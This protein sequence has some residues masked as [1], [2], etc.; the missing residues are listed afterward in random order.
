MAAVWLARPTDGLWRR[1]SDAVNRAL[2]ERWL[3]G[4]LERVLKTDLFD[5]AVGDGL[6][7]A[8]AARADRVVGIDLNVAIVEAAL[9]R[10]PAT[11]GVVA[12]VRALP[13]DDGSF[14]A[15][16][17]NS[18]LDHFDDESQISRAIGELG[19]VL[20]PGGRLVLTLD[21][22]ANPV[23]ALAKALP[24]QRLNRVWRVAGRGTARVGLVPYYVG[25]TLDRAAMR[26]RARAAGLGPRA[27]TTLVHAPRVLAV[28]ATSLLEGHAP[29]A[30]ER[31][32][33]LLAAFERLATTPA[34]RFT[35]HLNALLAVKPAGGTNGSGPPGSTA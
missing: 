27:E 1:H 17:S 29:G 12:D 24:R 8:L 7:P 35:A 13:F 32:L 33:R 3:P 20:R 10:H 21:N 15:V 6:A 23:L 31:F 30:Q 26:E 34:A 9:R 18:T 19:R 28:M 11:E 5:E 4:P 25:A 14:D 22:P 2:L 16:V